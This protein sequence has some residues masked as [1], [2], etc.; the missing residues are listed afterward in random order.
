MKKE[1]NI[2]FHKGILITLIIGLVLVTGFYIIANAI[3][4]YTGYSA[5]EIDGED[6]E[7]CL[8]EQNITLFINTENPAEELRK[9]DFGDYLKDM[10][11]INCFRNNNDCLERELNFFP[12][13]IINNKIIAGDISLAEL[14]GISGCQEP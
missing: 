2:K 14:L 11:I 12:T 8:K 4:K 3:T 5:L 10:K 6:N 7:K 1:E 9:I 13:W